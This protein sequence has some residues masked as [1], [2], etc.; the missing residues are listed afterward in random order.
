MNVYATILV[1]SFLLLKAPDVPAQDK[2]VTDNYTIVLKQRTYKIV[3]PLG[4]ID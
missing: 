3:A 4:I 2:A 1:S